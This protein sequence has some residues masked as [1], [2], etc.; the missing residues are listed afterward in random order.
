MENY[1][2]RNPKDVFGSGMLVMLDEN[3]IELINKENKKY[4]FSKINRNCHTKEGVTS[5]LKEIQQG[6]YKDIMREMSNVERDAKINEAKIKYE[7]EKALK[8]K[9][10]YELIQKAMEDSFK[11]MIFKPIEEVNTKEIDYKENLKENNKIDLNYYEEIDFKK[12]LIKFNNSIGSIK[13]KEVNN[14]KIINEKKIKF[15]LHERV[16]IDIFKHW[17][18]LGEIEILELLSKNNP[19][20]KFLFSSCV[21]EDVQIV[22]FIGAEVIISFKNIL[23]K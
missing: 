19:K 2:I 1:I 18:D 22:P 20:I 15:V 3:S 9:P 12:P 17:Y 4:Q 11:K 10:L 23:I 8:N 13:E 7:S 14:D 16:K 5:L 6:E 21:F